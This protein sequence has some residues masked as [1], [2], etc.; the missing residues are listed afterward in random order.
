MNAGLRPARLDATDAPATLAERALRAGD[1]AAVARL[2]ERALAGEAEAARALFGG[3]VE[4]LCD[5]FTAQGARACERV[6]AQVI[7]VARGA[8]ACAPLAEALAA[9]GIDGERGL[10]ARAGWGVGV[11]VRA[12]AP[13]RIAVLSRVTLG[14]DLAVGVPLARALAARWPGAEVVLF[15]PE[16]LRPVAEGIGARLVPATYGRREGLAARLN[17]WADL[18]AALRAEAEGLPVDGWLLVDPDTRLTQLGLLAPG[19][20]AAYRRLPSRVSGRGSLGA[21][22]RAWLR[23]AFDAGAVASPLPLRPEDAAFSRRLRAAM[24]ADGRRLVAVGF[25]TGGNPAKR[26]GPRFEAGIVGAL[27]AAGHRVLLSRGVDAAER[28]VIGALCASL[29]GGGT[30]VKHL[31]DGRALDPPGDADVVTWRADPGAFLAAVAA[32]DAHVGYDSAGQHV[33]AALAVPTLTAFVTASGERHADRWSPSGPGPVDVVRL[34]P[35]GSERAAT[36]AA[37]VALRALLAS[38]RPPPRVASRGRSPASRG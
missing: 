3:V 18:R 6:L 2:A 10:L 5:G 1:R 13:R 17:A 35:G 33:A 24:T 26:V 12:M 9:E 8:P 37:L 32:A 21:I 7:D 23:A 27:V 30:R 11:P 28:A 31:P 34:P 14:A 38:G 36:E 4:P 15:G 29:A 25:G 22:A 16:T 20:R 19:P